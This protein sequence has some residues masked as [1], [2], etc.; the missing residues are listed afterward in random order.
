MKKL[1][2]LFFFCLINSVALAQ[3]VE[4]FNNTRLQK[5]KVGMLILGS[6]AI[7]NLVA[8]PILASQSTGSTKHF[9]QMNGYWNI[10]NAALAGFGYLGVRS[11]MQ[12]ELGLTEV[13]DEQIK[14][15]KLLLFNSALDIGYMLGGAY[16]IERSKNT[17]KKPERLKGFGQSLM[18]QGGFLL[19]F[20]AIFYFSL[21][22][23]HIQMMDWMKTLDI[24]MQGLGLNFRYRF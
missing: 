4:Q 6:W 10:V 19:V 11:A 24:S 15:E 13:L 8:S 12:Q 18:L 5:N 23:D 1:L 22:Q 9:H 7:G 17:L 3:S 16:L 21:H 14:L 2:I 20:D